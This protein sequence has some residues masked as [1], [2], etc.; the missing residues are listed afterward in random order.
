MWIQQIAV[1]VLCIACTVHHGEAV[2]NNPTSV[3]NAESGNNEEIKSEEKDTVAAESNLESNRRDAPVLS[4]SYGVPISPGSLNAYGPPP[5]PAPVYGVPNHPSNNVVYPPPPPDIPPPVSTSYVDGNNLDL[6]SGSYGVPNFKP[7]VPFEKYGPPPNL[8]TDFGPPPPPPVKYGPPKLPKPY[9]SKPFK[10]RPAYGP[11][12]LHY[13]KSPKPI[14]GPP[15]H[16]RKPKPSYGPPKFTYGP[17]G[18]SLGPSYFNN[19]PPKNVYG[20]PKYVISS[21]H[22]HYGPPD[23]V[24]H[25]P[26]PGVPAPPTPP[27]IKYDGW[28]PIPG[29]VSRPPSDSYGVPHGEPHGTG[30]LLLNSDF[31]PPPVGGV[32]DNH[33]SID[34]HSNVNLFSS[35]NNGAVSD[36]YGAPL[37][38]VTGSGKI[39]TSAVGSNDHHGDIKL[40]LSAV[41]VNSGQNDNLAVIKSIGYEI[42]QQSNG[43]YYVNNNGGIHSS[44]S[45]SKDV[46]SDAFSGGISN[47]F[48]SDS[49]IQ[50][51]G[52]TGGSYLPP[53]SG[54]LILD[55][56]SAPPSDS[57]SISG[58]Y[59]ASHSYKSTGLSSS[60]TNSFEQFKKYPSYKPEGG[61]SDAATHG[62][63]VPPSGHYGV[64]P[65]GQ[66]GT[67]LIDSSSFLNALEINPPRHPVVHREPVPNGVLQ[68]L[69]GRGHYH[70]DAKGL[71]H[72]IHSAQSARGQFNAASTYIPPPV[73]DTLKPVNENIPQISTD[74]SLPS[75]HTHSSFK[76]NSVAHSNT[77]SSTVNI[78]GAQSAALTS[79]QVPSTGYQ[80]SS[81]YQTSLNSADGIYG[82]PVTSFGFIQDNSHSASVAD[83]SHAGINVALSQNQG[84][85]PFGYAGVPH[86]C[87]AYK[88]QP[89]PEITYGVPHQNAYSSSLSSNSNIGGSYQGSAQV[90]YGVPDQQSSH[91]QIV[92]NEQRGNNIEVNDKESFAKNL[93]PGAEVIPSQSIDFHNVPIQV[94]NTY[95]VQIQNSENTHSDIS[96]GQYL[97]D[98]LLQSVLNAVEQTKVNE[99]EARQNLQISAT[100][101]G[102]GLQQQDLDSQHSIRNE[103]Y[104]S[105]NSLNDTSSQSEESDSATEDSP[106]SL[107]GNNEIALYFNKNMGKNSGAYEETENSSDK[108]EQ[109]DSF[110]YFGESESSQSKNN[111]TET[112]SK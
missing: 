1:V 93:V 100:G 21:P 6:P 15:K 81:S 95:T 108:P 66:Y 27:E 73:P 86:D 4:D 19:G 112:V 29:L 55:S 79:Y 35:S 76:D 107:I 13:T 42:L 103:V 2:V 104:A 68:S 5:L 10:P 83:V 22:N 14:Y 109:F 30:D 89:L 53:V 74:L 105:S 40:G 47:S 8:S 69:D 60:K 50:F 45:G 110:G 87:S 56:Y 94:P 71:V 23:P 37:N 7:G 51:V 96:S 64:P 17:P 41:G 38:A 26:P 70:K 61:L 101:P 72:N 20:P 9:I 57:Y 25:P 44:S 92:T 67:P 102:A 24:P 98:A 36:S 111:T 46:H 80:D 52:A 91:S 88:S 16:Y 54:N 63:L 85:Y 59:A 99:Q 90:T 18:I 31:T 48:L 32:G 65:S 33:I 39:V 3:N 78:Q 43:Q 97:N 77:Y 106:L 11:P 34:S 12:K 28:K 62:G 49:D 84:A 82:I 75:V 58:P